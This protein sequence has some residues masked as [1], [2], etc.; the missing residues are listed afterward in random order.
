ME[1]ALAK[2]VR[3]LRNMEKQQKARNVRGAESVREDEDLQRLTKSIER[4]KNAIKGMQAKMAKPRKQDVDTSPAAKPAK[5][6]EQLPLGLKVMQ[7]YAGSG[8]Y[9]APAVVELAAKKHGKSHKP[10]ST[11]CSVYTGDNE[12]G[13]TGS[14]L[15][16]RGVS[17]GLDI[18]QNIK[19]YEKWI[20]SAQEKV[21]DLHE[22]YATAT[23]EWKC[24]KKDPVAFE[25]KQVALGAAKGEEGDINWPYVQKKYLLDTG[26]RRDEAM[27]QLQYWLVRKELYKRK[28][29]GEHVPASMEAEGCRQVDKVMDR[30][31]RLLDQVSEPPLVVLS[32]YGIL[33]A[34]HN[35]AEL[36]TMPEEAAAFVRKVKRNNAARV[37]K[38]GDA[39]KRVVITLEKQRCMRRKYY[40]LMYLCKK[41][42]MP[43]DD[44]NFGAKDG[45]FEAGVILDRKK[46]SLKELLKA[47][48]EYAANNILDKGMKLDPNEPP[49]SDDESDS[50]H[51]W[52]EEDVQFLP[53]D[54]VMLNGGEVTVIQVH[55]AENGTEYTVRLLTNRECRIPQAEL[56]EIE[57]KEPE[58]SEEMSIEATREECEPVVDEFVRLTPDQKFKLMQ[59]NAEKIPAQYHWL[60]RRIASQYPDV[61]T[62]IAMAKQEI[63]ECGVSLDPENK[64]YSQ[65][66]TFISLAIAMWEQRAR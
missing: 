36:P 22:Q 16:S 15:F 17:S 33:D 29:S 28:L 34:I 4:M 9:P 50:D 43:G 54:V 20:E 37:K 5:H 58:E 26:Y 65:M 41:W 52:M 60:R 48:K 47:A 6:K 10:Q 66:L 27:E 44:E 13:T 31:R 59:V 24:C 40:L 1:T 18:Q 23:E 61:N 35:G 11:F 32:C 53:G 14:I 25:K 2:A 51:E 39:C 30:F 19:G 3:D 49:S 46:E 64:N 42:P 62:A 56:T 45:N 21:D 12:D 57:P 55:N 38:Y 8:L 7:R 63:A